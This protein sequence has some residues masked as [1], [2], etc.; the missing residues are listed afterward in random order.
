MNYTE[1]SEKLGTRDSRKVANNTYLKREPE[2]KD[3]HVKLHDTNVVTYHE[4]GSVTFNSGGWRTMTT[5]DRMRNWGPF[6]WGG[7]QSD[8]GVWTIL[9]HLFFDGITF[10]KDRKVLNSDKIDVK[11]LRKAQKDIKKYVAGY[12]KALADCKIPAPSNGDCWFCLMR[13]NGTKE[14]LGEKSKDNDHISG[15]FK[16]KYYVPSLLV[17]AIEVFPVSDAAKCYLG[18]KWGEAASKDK[19]AWQL[20]AEWQLSSSLRKYL[21]RQFNLAS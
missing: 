3:I 6:R 16:E 11:D 18:D 10:D 21:N 8:R 15:H 13:V 12:M 19:N 7:L 4:D 17:R 5:A 2:T 14:T 1:A 9:G 20:V